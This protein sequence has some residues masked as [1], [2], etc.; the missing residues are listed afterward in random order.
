VC[1]GVPATTAGW[2]PTLN[3]DNLTS[4]AQ[5]FADANGNVSFPASNLNLR[6]HLFDGP[7]P[8]GTLFNCLRADEPDPGNGLPSYG[9]PGTADCQVRMATSL[10]APTTDQAFFSFALVRPPQ[11]PEAPYAILLP[12]GALLLFG[13]G[14]VV[15]RRRRSGQATA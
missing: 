11:V 15:T 7:S 9:L 3:C 14:Y 4:P 1:D 6:L 12:T 2:D 13:G 8:S 10:T 5:V